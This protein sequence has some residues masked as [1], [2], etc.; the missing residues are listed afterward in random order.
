[1]PDAPEPSFMNPVERAPIVFTAQSRH[2]FYARMLICRYALEHGVVPLNPFTLWGYFLDDMVDRDVVR[3]ANNNLVR[4]ADELWVF[5]PVSDGVLYEIRLAMGLGK[6]LRFFSA[7]PTV[8]DIVPLDVG[9]I[10]FEPDLA[11]RVEITEAI[12][13]YAGLRRGALA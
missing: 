3:A 4:R 9:D 7:G 5:G 13:R 10:E 11:G 2:L 8:A 1:M 12:D 6:P